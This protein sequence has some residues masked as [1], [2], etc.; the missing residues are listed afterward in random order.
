MGRLDGKVALITG[1]ARGMGKSHVRHFVAEGA[2][3]MFGDVLDDLGEAVA[4]ELGEALPLPAPRRQQ[5]EPTGRRRSSTAI[6]TFG[7]LDILVNNAG[8]S[9]QVPDHRDAARRLPALSSTS[10]RSAAGSA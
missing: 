4:D 2:K 6:E 8:I 7:R 3:V 9:M 1:G 5:R 10:T